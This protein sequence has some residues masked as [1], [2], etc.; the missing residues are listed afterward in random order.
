MN[1]STD[2]DLTAAIALLN[3]DPGRDVVARVE[4]QVDGLANDRVMR[5]SV[6]VMRIMLEVLRLSDLRSAKFAI[7]LVDA[8][9]KLASFG[10]N[11]HLNPQTCDNCHFAAVVS[12]GRG[13][14]DPDAPGTKR[15]NVCRR[16]PPTVR[17]VGTGVHE[18]VTSMFSPT[19]P[20][21]WCGMWEFMRSRRAGA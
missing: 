12:E 9:T 17:V 4:A 13:E 15:V 1:A 7:E 14:I 6:G 16:S 10:I 3:S 11:T 20:A 5:T 8:R 19:S 18:V 21:N 2:S